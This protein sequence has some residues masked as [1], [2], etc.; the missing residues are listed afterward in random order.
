VDQG[1]LEKVPCSEHPR[2]YD[3]AARGRDLW[4]I[5]TVMRQWGNKYA[6]PDGPPLQVVQKACGEVSQAVLTC[7]AGGERLTA[8]GVRA[9]PG[10]GDLDHLVHASRG[11]R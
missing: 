4:P 7:S 2:R 5:L 6:A 3:L 10:T 8:R 9:V 1:I 11:D